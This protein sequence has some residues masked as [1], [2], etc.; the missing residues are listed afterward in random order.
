MDLPVII[1]V[2]SWDLDISLVLLDLLSVTFQKI[3]GLLDVIPAV[4]DT[5]L[6]IFKN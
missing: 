6:A 5:V 3:Q 1:V 4:L 2:N